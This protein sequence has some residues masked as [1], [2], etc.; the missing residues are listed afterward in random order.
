MN[1]I[2]HPFSIT[3][4]KPMIGLYKG[5]QHYSFDDKIVRLTYYYFTIK[6]IHIKNKV[7]LCIMPIIGSKKIAILTINSYS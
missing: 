1:R 3:N 7:F 4:N 6:I 5:F 2:H